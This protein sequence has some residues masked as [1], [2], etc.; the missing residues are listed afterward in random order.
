MYLY[1][2]RDR[3]YIVCRSIIII[4]IMRITML[5][6]SK[7]E[8]LLRLSDKFEHI[9]H[10]W[11]TLIIIIIYFLPHIHLLSLCENIYAKKNL[12]ES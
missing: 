2:Q 11:T 8:H 12:N 1:K 6:C 9:Q 4:I 3:V 7:L 10:N 5:G